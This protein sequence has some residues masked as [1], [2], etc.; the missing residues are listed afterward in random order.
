MHARRLP[1]Q[2]RPV[3]GTGGRKEGNPYNDVDFSAL[4]AHLMHLGR[5]VLLLLL[6]SM[7]SSV[8]GG[9]CLLC[10]LPPVSPCNPSEWLGTYAIFLQV[11]V[12]EELCTYHHGIRQLCSM[13]VA[14]T[15]GL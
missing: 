12:C 6:H 4:F 5:E 8:Y 7:L 3:P 9:L 1:S 14:N 10:Y 2:P 11:D 13:R 15:F